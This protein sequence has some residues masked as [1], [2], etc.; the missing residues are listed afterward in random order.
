MVDILPQI[1]SLGTSVCVCVC[2]CVC[3]CVCVEWGGGLAFSSQGDE[4][5]LSH[6]M[7]D[8]KLV[9]YTY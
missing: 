3:V 9:D 5:T 8:N 2:A 7:S 1:Y 6:L 4:V